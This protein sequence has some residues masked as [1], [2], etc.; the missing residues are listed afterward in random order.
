MDSD[1]ESEPAMPIGGQEENPK[2]TPNPDD[3]PNSSIESKVYKLNLDKE[4]YSL[5][6][7]TF[8]NGNI[9]FKVLQN[10]VESSV[11][12]FKEYKY[13]EILPKLYLFKELCDS[14]SKVL[15]YLDAAISK[16]KVTLNK[17]NKIM[18]IIIKKTSDIFDSEMQTILELDEAAIKN[19]DMLK[20]LMSDIG[21]LKSKGV[22]ISNN[23]DLQKLI[24][25]NEEMKSKMKLIMEQNEKYK[26]EIEQLKNTVKTLTEGKNK[27]K[28]QYEEQLKLLLSEIKTIKKN[29]EMFSPPKKSNDDYFEKDPNNL[30]FKNLLA[31]D[32]SRDGLLANFVVY[33]GLIDGITYLVYN[34]RNNF[35]LEVMRIRDKV[36]VRSLKKHTKPVSVIRYFRKNNREEYLLSCEVCGGFVI[37]WDIINNF[38]IINFIQEQSAGKIYDALLLFNLNNQDYVLI[39]SAM[40]EP[41]KLFELREN[42]KYYNIFGT[43]DNLTN[44]MIPWSYNNNYYIIKLYSDISIHNIFRNECYAKLHCE[45]S[46]YYCGYIFN[47]NY[48]CANDSASFCLR[49]WDLVNKTAIKNIKYDIERGKEI[50]PWNSKYTIVSGLKFICVVDI[51]NEKVTKKIHLEKTCLGGVKKVYLN[52][53]GECIIVSDFSSNIK[54]FSL[55]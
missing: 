17:E 52:H 21:E 14:I 45:K 23:Q 2:K 49:I 34:N 32:H 44:Y 41:I 1:K 25:D 40:K 24:K 10:N 18:K 50:V 3:L 27:E 51:E 12:Y 35:N 37:I 54:L 38:N 7:E 42:Q 6:I 11:Y 13:D 43:E 4:I 16:N 8:T 46:Q 28:L 47:K 9:T 39:S 5:T 20:M 26:K 22:G 31:N 36:Y 48:L 30:K 29:L 55:E 15:K 53:L 19:E 33:T